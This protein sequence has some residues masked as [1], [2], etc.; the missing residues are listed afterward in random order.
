MSGNSGFILVDR[1]TLETIDL[2]RMSQDV[3]KLRCRIAQVPLYICRSMYNYTWFSKSISLIHIYINTISNPTT[4]AVDPMPAPISI[5][6]E[7]LSSSDATV[8]QEVDNEI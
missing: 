6:A 8:R 3:G 5:A 4:T 7:L 1:N 2:C